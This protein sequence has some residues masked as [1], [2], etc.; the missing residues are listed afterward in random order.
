MKVIFL[1]LQ[2]TL[3]LVVQVWANN[4]SER[5]FYWREVNAAGGGLPMVENGEDAW[6]GHCLPKETEV[7]QNPPACFSKVPKSL[8]PPGIQ[9]HKVWVLGRLSGGVTEHLGLA[10][11]I[12]CWVSAGLALHG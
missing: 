11:W 1:L 7:G 12:S 5:I 3:L 4:P 10:K 2:L 6:L 9:Q 8:R